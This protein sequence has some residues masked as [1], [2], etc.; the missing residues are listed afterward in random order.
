MP[1]LPESDASDMEYFLSQLQIVLPVLGVNAIRVRP[2]KTPT[3]TVIE[4]IESPI[5][6][7]KNA[8]TGVDSQAQQIDGEF[9]VLAGST[10]VPAWRGSGKA[11]STRKAYASYQAQHQRLVD[12]GTIAVENGVGRVTRDIVFSSPST[13]GAIVT[14]R[15]CNGRREW[16][17]SEG[18]FGDWESRGVE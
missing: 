10:V 7:L 13:A 6:L 8:K 9:T 12:D 3:P 16:V 2:T 5:F 4:T 18:T 15:A 11:E 14:G 17:S 1:A